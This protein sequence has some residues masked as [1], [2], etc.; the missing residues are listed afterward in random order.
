LNIRSMRPLVF[1]G[2]GALRPAS[3]RS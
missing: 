2:C 3:R 1:M